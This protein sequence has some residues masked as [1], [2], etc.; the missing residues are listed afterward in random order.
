MNKIITLLMHS[1]VYR[2]YL[3]QSGSQNRILFPGT[4]FELQILAHS[5]NG[6]LSRIQI[7]GNLKGK[8]EFV[9]GDTGTSLINLSDDMADN[10]NCIIA[11]RKYA[12]P[13]NR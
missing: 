13:H 8:S 9:Y 12:F 11:G 4:D 3:V 6:S 7:S 10:L 2:D 1:L 5:E